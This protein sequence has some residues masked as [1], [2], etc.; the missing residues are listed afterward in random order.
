MIDL[1]EICDISIEMYMYGVNGQI[2]RNATLFLLCK[3]NG[4]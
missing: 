1:F 3:L 2:E 4:R